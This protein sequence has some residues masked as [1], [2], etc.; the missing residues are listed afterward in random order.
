LR[1][2]ADWQILFGGP[3]DMPEDAEF[4]MGERLS[5]VALSETAVQLESADCCFDFPLI[6]VSTHRMGWLQLLAGSGE[7]DLTHANITFVD[8]TVLALDM[9]ASGGGLAIARGP[10]SHALV[11]RTGLVT[12]AVVPQ[13]S[14][15]Q[16][17]FLVSGT[18]ASQTPA[19]QA[20]REWL[21]TESAEARTHTP[22]SPTGQSG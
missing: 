8:N 5:V 22:L 4:L 2:Q 12:C 3:W 17:Y 10:A 21:I 16:G 11:E 1:T 6:E 13:A 14:S 20:F 7:R 9:A 15:G 19:A 18:S